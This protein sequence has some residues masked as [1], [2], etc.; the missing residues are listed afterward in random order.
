MNI[1]EDT[2]LLQHK[3][4]QSIKKQL[5]AEHDSNCLLFLMD[6]DKRS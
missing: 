3:Q 6:T 1:V 5:N 4:N 2:F